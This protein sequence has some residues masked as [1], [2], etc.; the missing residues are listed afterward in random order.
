MSLFFC[1]MTLKVIVTTGTKNGGD[2][3]I[4]KGLA[5]ILEVGELFNDVIAS[6]TQLFECQI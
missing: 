6:L 5:R 4:V 3:N 1:H 2:G